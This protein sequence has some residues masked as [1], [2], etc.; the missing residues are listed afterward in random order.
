MLDIAIESR[1]PDTKQ[2][3][4]CGLVKSAS[5]YSKAFNRE[6]RRFYLQ[7]ECKSCVR[8][9]S[10]RHRRAKGMEKR[11]PH[12]I[13]TGFKTC[14]A[15]KIEKPG[16]EFPVSL[17]R[18]RDKQ[19]QHGNCKK[20]EQEKSKERRHANLAVFKER[21]MKTDR[22]KKFGLLHE[23]YLKMAKEQNNLCAICDR[24]EINTFIGV[25]RC[26]SVDHDHV[27]GKVRGLLCFKCNVSIGKFDES[28]EI[29]E[30]AI[31]Y[32]KKHKGV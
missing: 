4:T 3:K 10:E 23:D 27:T 19:Y 14:I 32:L 12:E 9:R 8:L 25:V 5:E 21:R 20:C 16:S 15:C 18:S 2:C 28:I 7:S 31:T 13:A 26:L 29:L 17:D 24:P 11:V 6:V 1:V 30:K 22:L